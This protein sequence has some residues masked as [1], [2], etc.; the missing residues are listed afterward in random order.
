MNKIDQT[1]AD[2]KIEL[3][4]E[5]MALRSKWRRPKWIKFPVSMPEDTRWIKLSDPA[6]VAWLS[7]LIIA[8]EDP[9]WK[10]PRTEIL[11][12]RLRIFGNH[13]HISAVSRIIHEYIQCG[14]LLSTTPELQSHRVTEKKEE[15]R[16]IEPVDNCGKEASLDAPLSLAQPNKQ[17]AW[18]GSEVDRLEMAD[19]FYLLKQRLR[20]ND[21]S[22]RLEA[23]K[24]KAVP[25]ELAAEIG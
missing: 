23:V 3:S 2:F 8:S 25:R 20:L 19:K 21:L 13:Y 14:F 16:L 9:N 12:N 7:I 24:P 11:V 6:K 15:E 18:R 10:L 5:W 17:E 4:P 22:A 1:I